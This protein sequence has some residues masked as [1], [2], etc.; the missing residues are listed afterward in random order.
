MLSCNHLNIYNFKFS[1]CDAITLV[2][3][4][5]N[6]TLF[7][8]KIPQQRAGYLLVPLVAPNGLVVCNGTWGICS[9]NR[10]A[11]T[12][13]VAAPGSGLTENARG[14]APREAE[15]MPNERGKS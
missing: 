4:L 2:F 1:F 7:F 8:S 14:K 5:S 11:S 12:S 13:T 3:L 6:F 10:F 15:T 9:V